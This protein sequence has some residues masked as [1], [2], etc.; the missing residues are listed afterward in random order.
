[1]AES[2]EDPEQPKKQKKKQKKPSLNKLSIGSIIMNKASGNDGIPGKLFQILKA[3]TP[4]PI[5]NQSVVPCPVL[6]LLYLHT[7]FS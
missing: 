5:W 1:M 4:F 3:D 2:K 6:F 7:D